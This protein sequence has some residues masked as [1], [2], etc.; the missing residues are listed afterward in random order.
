[1]K[2][3]KKA[4]EKDGQKNR[5]NYHIIVQ[6]VFN[7]TKN[8]SIKWFLKRSD[9]MS[10]IY[11]RVYECTT[12]EKLQFIFSNYWNRE[13]KKVQRYILKFREKSTPIAMVSG[14]K[15]ESLIKKSLS[16]NSNRLN[17]RYDETQIIKIRE[18]ANLPQKNVEADTVYIRQNNGR[19]LKY[20]ETEDVVAIIYVV[21]SM[22]EIIECKMPALYCNTCESYYISRTIIGKIKKYGKPLCVIE[23]NDAREYKET[24]I[25]FDLADES[26]L[27]LIG[28]NVGTKDNLS[29]RQRQ[30]LLD[31]IIDFSIMKKYK[32]LEYLELFIN[33][34]GK[35]SNMENCVN[36]WN[37]DWQHVAHYNSNKYRW[38]HPKILREQYFV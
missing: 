9:S 16:N 2:N 33:M 23:E 5:I 6:D 31:Y 20:H 28:Y 26:P 29:E 17:V 35:R 8:G 38:I 14:E 24:S 3:K 34:N 37:A 4:D 21:T 7:K 11:Q 13:G 19:C 18:L 27:H 1:M 25:G 32:V 36:K 22:G 15:F 12:D 30:M 10:G